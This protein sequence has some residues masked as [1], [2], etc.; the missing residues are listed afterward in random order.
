MKRYRTRKQKVLRLA[1]GI[2]ALCL[3]LSLTNAVNFV[4]RQALRD[5]AD[6]QN[7]TEPRVIRS[8]YDNKLKVYRLARQYLVEGKEGLM[9]CAVGWDPLL[10]WYD[11]DWCAV[12][13]SKDVPVHMGY[14]AHTQGEG[15]AGYVFG[16]IDDAAVAEIVLRWRPGTGIEDDFRY[17]ELPQEAFFKENGK[18]Y[19]LWETVAVG[20]NGGDHRFIDELTV[21][22]YDKD[23]MPLYEEEIY[24][25]SWGSAA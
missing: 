2:V 11:R 21:L 7:M 25:Q 16:R 17:W 14:R 18:R 20:E 3:L 8:F 5:T 19:L 24:W 13:T 10:G 1:V 12:G 6:T 9:L 4:P 22:A 15:Y 23:G